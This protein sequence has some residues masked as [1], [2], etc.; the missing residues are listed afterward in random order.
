MNVREKITPQMDFYDRLGQK[1]RPFLM[2]LHPANVKSN[3]LNTD[4]LGI[5]YTVKENIQLSPKSSNKDLGKT[6]SVLIGGSTVFGVGAS[7]DSETISSHLSRIRNQTFLNLGGRAYTCNQERILFDHI[8]YELPDITNVV[9]LSGVNDIDATKFSSEKDHF[10]TF[11]LISKYINSMD[12]ATTSNIR[13]VLKK[14]LQPVLGN[15]EQYSNIKMKELI[16]IL[17]NK[18]NEKKY[19]FSSSTSPEIDVALAIKQIRKSLFTWKKLSQAYPFKLSYILQP[20][21]SWMNKQLSNEELDL[22]RYLDSFY[23]TSTINSFL[24]QEIYQE[25]TKELSKLC[26][27]FEISYFDSNRLFSKYI[28]PTDWVFVDR[29]HLTDHGNAKLAQMISSLLD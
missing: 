6:V 19:Y 12:K 7:S 16:D 29:V 13:W 18:S 28:G 14:L 27:D 26:S 25:Y 4:E 10:G 15:E 17:L 9:I 11:Y 20:F 23:E 2:Y 8:A 3:Y 1:W 24:T 22:F 21:P 5:R